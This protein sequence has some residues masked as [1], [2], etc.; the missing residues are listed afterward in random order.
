MSDS[1][2]DEHEALDASFAPIPVL[3]P[4]EQVEEQLRAAILTGQLDVGS[5]LP[6]E[7]VLAAQ[8]S[9]SRTTV[10]EALRSLATKGLIEK[11]PGAG[12]GSFVRNVDHWSLGRVVQEGMQNLLQLG[13]IQEAEASD[14]RY[15]LEVPAAR[16]AALH[17]RD[18]DI[19][20]LERIIAQLSAASH[21]DPNVPAMDAQLHT[22]VAL[23]SDN[24]VLASLVYALHR[25]TEPVRH[26]KLTAE[27]GK[28][29]H[30]QHQR[31]VEAIKAKD[32]DAAEEAMIEHL[33]YLKQHPKR[34]SSVKMQ[35]AAVR[36]APGP[37][38][39]QDQR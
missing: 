8:F 18:S 35:E 22:T 3:R 15:M 24:R 30:R 13:T 12:G 16:L 5:R 21:D 11:T 39:L 20:V 32:P 37:V 6:S 2:V 27:V 33:S 9:V 28:H 34:T 29:S 1:A 36:S 19:R 25:S 10:R 4:R 23:M 26:L 14:V 7:T 17:R 31:L 38:S